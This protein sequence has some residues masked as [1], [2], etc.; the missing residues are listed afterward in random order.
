VSQ[1][2]GVAA[3]AEPAHFDPSRQAWILGRYD[4]VRAALAEPRLVI[5]GTPTGAPLDVTDGLAASAIPELPSGWR[6]ASQRDAAEIVDVLPRHG[7][8]DLVAQY[9]APWSLAVAR[10]LLG[11]SAEVAERCLP[12]ART[13][14]LEAARATDGTPSTVAT[15][16]AGALAADLH[17][18]T[19]APRRAVNVQAWVALTQSLPAMLASMW[20]ALLTH[21]EQIVRLR[22]GL[23]RAAEPDLM[24]RAIAE[25]L[26]FAGPAHAVFRTAQADVLIGGA[27]IR[28]NDRVILLLSAANRDSLH[29]P[30]APLLN[31]SRR[32]TAHL[33]F[34]DGPHRCPGASLMRTATTIATETLLRR[35]DTIT[36]EP[37][38]ANSEIG[39][40]AIRAPATVW[41]TFTSH[42]V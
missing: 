35:A 13:V 6:V 12:L 10:R 32:V 8:V 9:F 28:A 34:G 1:S 39:G 22:D 38:I 26:R 20:L 3:G 5:H 37:T 7:P 21:P 4:D 27:A 42:S 23:H 30:D 24:S 18:A 29:F 19:A 41:A 11:V 15:D 31:V 40:F 14:F 2:D 36:L 25:L 16:A 17:D 33:A